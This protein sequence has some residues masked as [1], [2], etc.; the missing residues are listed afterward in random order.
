MG[1][2]GSSSQCDAVAHLKFK[3]KSLCRI[4][5]IMWTAF[6]TETETKGCNW[7]IIRARGQTHTHSIDCSV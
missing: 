3:K 7:G 5:C 2:S 6:G 1:G 4:V